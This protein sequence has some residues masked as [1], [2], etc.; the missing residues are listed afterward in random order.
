MGAK[1]STVDVAGA[2][3]PLTGDAA[4]TAGWR[5]NKTTGTFIANYHAL[6]GDGTTFYDSF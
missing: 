6:S 1:N 5:Y 4:P 2:T 3:D